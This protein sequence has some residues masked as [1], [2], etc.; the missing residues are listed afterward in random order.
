[1]TNLGVE[2]G[3]A[4]ATASKPNIEK[5]RFCKGARGQLYSYCTFEQGSE[6]ISAGYPR[7]G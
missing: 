6:G 2:P 5:G 4:T 3:K 7:G 1:M